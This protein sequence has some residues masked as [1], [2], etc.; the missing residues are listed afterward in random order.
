MH[1]ELPMGPLRARTLRNKAKLSRVSGDLWAAEQLYRQ[2]IDTVDRRVS[3][4]R[5]LVP[6]A[7]ALR[8]AGKSTEALQCI[9]R[10][11]AWSAQVGSTRSQAI[12]W[13][14]KAT[15]LAAAE[16][17]GAVLAEANAAAERALLGHQSIGYVQGIRET[18]IVL[19][20]I[21]LRT[22]DIARALE[23]FKLATPQRAQSDTDVLEVVAAELDAN[24][25]EDRAA[26]IRQTV[27]AERQSA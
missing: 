6:Y 26:T 15:F 17:S 21:A 27:T 11:I 3:S 22:G 7:K 23:L 14:Y 12:G 1:R 4:H 5:F 18:Q 10:V 2:A 16:T 24:G 8:R 25:E 9:E 20:E 13:Q 19:G